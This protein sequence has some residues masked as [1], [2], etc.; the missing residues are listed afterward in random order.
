MGSCNIIK[1]AATCCKKLTNM[2]CNSSSD[3]DD[4]DCDVD[5]D[6]ENGNKQNFKPEF[7]AKYVELKAKT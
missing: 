1:M 2:R 6:S 3:D 7:N 4:I 5:S